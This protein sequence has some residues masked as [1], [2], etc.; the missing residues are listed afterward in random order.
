MKVEKDPNRLRAALLSTAF[1]ISSFF[2]AVCLASPSLQDDL[3]QVNQTFTF[4]LDG[5]LAADTYFEEIPSTSSTYYLG[6]SFIT[7]S[8]AYQERIRLALSANL[9]EL[10]NMSDISFDNEVDWEKF[11]REAYI[12]I[13]NINNAPVAI[14]I[15]KQPIFFGQNIQQMPSWAQGPLR[16]VQE[17]R[18]VFGITV[19]LTDTLLGLFDQIDYTLFEQEFGD[20]SI[21][22]LNGQ[23]IRFTKYLNKNLLLTIGAKRVRVSDVKSENQHQARVGLVGKSNN[24]KL[25]GWAEGIFLSNDPAYPGS[26]FAMTLG[27]SYELL[28]NSM[29]VVELNYVNKYLSQLGLGLKTQMNETLQAGVDLR[30][31]QNLQTNEI[32]YF[33]GFNLTYYFGLGSNRNQNDELHIF[34]DESF[35][36]FDEDLPQVGE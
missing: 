15:G 19:S 7:L 32:E 9:A 14:I 10:I 1:F 31:G 26:N 2:A 8:T 34:E 20:L 27:A 33:L 35:E 12:E 29:V 24:G 13:R 11:V 3:D 5:Q 30:M 4:N 28:P 21:G 25:I 18:E 22:K 6:E 17:I 23:N 36:I 16:P